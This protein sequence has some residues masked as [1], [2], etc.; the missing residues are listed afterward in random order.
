VTALRAVATA[1]PAAARAGGRLARVG[2]EAAGAAVALRRLSRTAPDATGRERAL[3]TRDLFARVAALHGIE[4][5]A[6]G[7]LPLGPALLASNHV[8]Y[9]D[10]IVAGSLVP[11]VPISKL[12]V[13]SWPVVGGF[14][15]DLGVLFVERGNGRSGAR[16]IRAAAR[17]LAGGVSILN[18]PEGTT[19]AGDRVLRFRE[20]LFGV[21]WSAG[22][23]VVP[24]AISYAPSDLAWIGAQTF[25][26]HY[27][28]LAGIERAGAV[29][30]FGAPLDPRAHG[31]AA[32]LAGAARARVAGM[33]G[34]TEGEWDSR[35]PSST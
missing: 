2:V 10:P 33:L 19:T 4:V 13:S 30:R 3:F 5:R 8:S 24:V 16:V 32:S 22:I 18:F 29:V 20:G 26:P 23:P 6:E 27:L 11:C 21:A 9:L 17:V 12:D 31:T 14:A 7:A 15:R 34:V 28:R 25:V 1:V 35:A